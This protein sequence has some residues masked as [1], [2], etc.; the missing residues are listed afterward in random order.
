MKCRALAVKIRKK[1]TKKNTYINGTRFDYQPRRIARGHWIIL[2]CAH[3]YVRTV[4]FSPRFYGRGI[5][6]VDGIIITFFFSP[7]IQYNKRE[8]LEKKTANRFV[9]FT[10]TRDEQHS[11]TERVFFVFFFFTPF[12]NHVSSSRPRSQSGALTSPPPPPPRI[13]LGPQEPSRKTRYAR[14]IRNTRPR[15]YGTQYNRHDR[16]PYLRFLDKK[17]K[18]LLPSRPLAHFFFFPGERELKEEANASGGEISKTSKLQWILPS[19]LP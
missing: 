5:P 13:P 8:K 6:K 9:L 15:G 2:F 18:T 11:S 3:K 4:L 16:D 14:T 1:N 10:I 7:F 17:K 19:P 12:P